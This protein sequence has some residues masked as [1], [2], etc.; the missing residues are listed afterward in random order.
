MTA[1]PSICAEMIKTYFSS[2]NKQKSTALFHRFIV[3]RVQFF[4]VSE[5]TSGYLG[6]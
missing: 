3:P 4:V 6:W 5:P 2:L 1:D